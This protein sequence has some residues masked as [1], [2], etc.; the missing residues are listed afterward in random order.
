GLA[1]GELADVLGIDGVDHLQRIALDGLGRAQAAAAQPA[2]EVPQA[3]PA[4][5]QVT[6]LRGSLRSAEA[7]KRDSLQVVDA[8]NAEDIGKF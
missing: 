3:A 2:P 1:V 7:I 5:V 4:V 6:G 8:I